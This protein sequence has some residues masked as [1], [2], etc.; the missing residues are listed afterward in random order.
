MKRFNPEKTMID[1][2]PNF[3]AVVG[4]GWLIFVIYLIVKVFVIGC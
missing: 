4:I 3:F 2:H 1:R